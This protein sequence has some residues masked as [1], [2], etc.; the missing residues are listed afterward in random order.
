M[1]NIVRFG[2]EYGGFYYPENLDGLD[3][4]SIVYCIGAGEDI[5]H[6]IM[7]ANKLNCKV[8]IMDPTPRAI[9][10]YKLVKDVF[11]GKQALV[12]SK[13]IG[14]GQPME[15]WNILMKHKIPVDNMVYKEYG[16]GAEEGTHKFYLPSNKEYV[17]CS[18]VEGRK[19][20]EY[21]NINVKKLKSVMNELGHNKI[22]LLKMD[23]EGSECDVIENMLKEEI[24]PKYLAVEFD[25]AFHGENIRDA[26]RYNQMIQK[27]IENNY[28][29]IYKNH[30]D[31]TFKL[32]TLLSKTEIL[33]LLNNPGPPNRAVY[34][35]KLITMAEGLEELNI[36]YDSNINYYKKTN[37]DFLFKKTKLLNYNNYDYIITSTNSNYLESVSY[38]DHDNIFIPE[39]IL[40][41]KN[42]KFK[43]II[44]DWADGFFDYIQYLEYY[45][46]WFKINYETNI[47]KSISN[48]VYPSIICST[49]RIMEHT[50][51]EIKWEDRYINLFYSHRINHDIRGYMLNLYKTI[52]NDDNFI[53]YFNDDFNEPNVNDSDYVNWCQTGRRHNPKFYEI[54]KHTKLMDCTAGF[55][56]IIN[57]NV[58]IVQND[59]WKLWEAFFAG[60]CVIAVDLDLFNIKFPVQPRNMFHYI[61][62]TLDSEKDMKIINDIIDG[63]IDIKQ[64][65]QNGNDFV[66]NNYTPKEFSKYV[67]KTVNFDIHISNN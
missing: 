17:S 58:V 31:F 55:K 15:Y 2:T 8:Y 41:S 34:Q 16:I 38:K 64:I 53:K 37:G 5:S 24:Y 44:F 22:D 25:L 28:E 36:K 4:N 48:K 13:S 20:S 14:G 32:K 54:L 11:E 3:E 50:K 21:I 49:N 9:E 1:D 52:I 57:N 29:L 12:Y 40:K 35:H 30:S 18:L 43:L 45:D 42:R 26:E 56:R 63:K 33:F 61:G 6:D 51:T 19:S 39:E 46:Y 59:S 60:C 27:L 67:L 66:R 23:I 7:V 47:I 62:M 65:A 10:H